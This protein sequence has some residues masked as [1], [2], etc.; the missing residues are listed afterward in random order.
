MKNW[1]ELNVWQKIVIGS[2]VML[3][4]IISPELMLFIDI[5]GIELAFSFLL[6]YYKTLI[7]WFELQITKCKTFLATFHTTLMNSVL[8]RPQFL[9]FHAAYCVLV[10]FVTGSLLFS[11]GFVGPACFIGADYL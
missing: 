7:A 11:L 10:F 4:A 3:A 1:Q 6:L 9:T 5:G 8:G 2:L